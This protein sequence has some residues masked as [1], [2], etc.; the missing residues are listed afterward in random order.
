M[1]VLFS[2][3]D[4]S[5]GVGKTTV[6]R[7]LGYQQAQRDTARPVHLATE[8]TGTVLGQLLRASESV[9]QGRALALALA[10]DRADHLESEIIPALDA[11]RH[12]ITDR[13]VQSSLVLQRIDGLD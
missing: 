9:L 1:S 5:N 2:A 10:A 11:G 6:V 7:L 3:I 12:V 4:G 8:P 13:Y